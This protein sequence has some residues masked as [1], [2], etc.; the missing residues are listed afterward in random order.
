METWEAVAGDGGVAQAGTA[1]V[2]ILM[3][4]QDPP[5]GT[6]DGYAGP[7]VYKSLR[8]LKPAVAKLSEPV[9]CSVKQTC[10]IEMGRWC[11]QV[12]YQGL[13]VNSST[14]R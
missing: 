9:L 12:F 4:L 8:Q 7:V 6:H 1:H 11:H 3:T 14:R 10:E 13:R 2:R 5:R